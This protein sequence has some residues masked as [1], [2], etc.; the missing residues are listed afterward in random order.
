MSA[1]LVVVLLLV[2][3]HLHSDTLR[4]CIIPLAFRLSSHLHSL[5]PLHFWTLQLPLHSSTLNS[6]SFLLLV[7]VSAMQS[8]S[9]FLVFLR[10]QKMSLGSIARACSRFSRES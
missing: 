6:F 7:L 9:L 10:K 1:E 2:E 3:G 8:L 5:S 4:L